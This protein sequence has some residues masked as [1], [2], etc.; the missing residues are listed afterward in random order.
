MFFFKLIGFG[1]GKLFEGET[2]LPAPSLEWPYMYTKWVTWTHG[3]VNGWHDF[4][5]IS[6]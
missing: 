2:G 6:Q 5:A 3:R 1:R 4:E